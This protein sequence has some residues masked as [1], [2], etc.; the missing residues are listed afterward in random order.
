MNKGKNFLVTLAMFAVS[1]MLSFLTVYGGYA[2]YNRGELKREIIELK[3]ELAFSQT[4]IKTLIDENNN[5]RKI[6]TFEQ[7]LLPFF[8]DETK[9]KLL[10]TEGCL[11]L[12]G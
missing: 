3:K 2:I 6:V 9:D 7:T 4:D 11:G 1:I 10:S 12:G 5:L 8:S